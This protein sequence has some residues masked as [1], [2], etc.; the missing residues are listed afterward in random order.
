MN[1]LKRNELFPGSEVSIDHFHCNPLGRLLHTYGKEKEDAKYKGG[2]IFVDH[3]TGFLHTELQTSLNSHS[4]LDAKV[5]FDDMCAAHGVVPQKFLSDNGTSFANDEFVAHLKEFA[6][7]IRHS[8]VGAHHSNGIAERGIS[9]LMSIARAMLHHAAIHW[10]DVANVELWPLAVLHAAHIINRIPRED[11]GRSPLELFSRKT[12]PSSKFHDLHVWGCPIYVLDSTL[13]DGH[14]LP[15]W[16]PRSSRCVCVGN[17]M[18]HGHAVPLVLNLDTGK[19]TAQCHVVYDDWFQTVDA[20]NESKIDFDHPDWH[21]TFGLTESQC[22]KDDEAEVD[23]SF[24]PSSPESEGVARSERARSV[25]DQ[26]TLQREVEPLK[27]LP[28]GLKQEAPSQRESQI[29]APL[30]DHSS[31]IF[32]SEGE[33]PHPDYPF[34]DCARTFRCGSRSASSQTRLFRCRNGVAAPDNFSE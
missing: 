25:R 26:V 13:S 3:A 21:Q 27:P 34:D 12:W 6:Q 22:V 33:D 24:H 4:T 14:K 18:N 29:P 15:R 23:P 30:P 5:R 20:T 11:T 1:S 7:T 31:A 10:P 8:S 17:S 16:K 32:D 2:C 9:T 28:T 19:I